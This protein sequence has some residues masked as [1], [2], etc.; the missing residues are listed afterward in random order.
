MILGFSHLSLSTTNIVESEKN[1]LKQGYQREFLCSQIPNHPAKLQ[2]LNV[3][4]PFH[5]IALYSHKTKPTLELIKHGNS[6]APGQGAFEYNDN[7]VVMHIPSAKSLSFYVESLNFR[8]EPEGSILSIKSPIAAWSLKIVIKECLPVR[9][10]SLDSPGCCVLALWCRNLEDRLNLL[11]RSGV[12]EYS[13]PFFVNINGK[14]LKVALFRSPGGGI[15]ELV[16]FK[17]R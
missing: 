6:F 14:E 9:E 7:H 15:F 11:K 2:F 5:D 13:E 10:C 17:S 16:E 8:K 4:E 3:F 12:T 1:I